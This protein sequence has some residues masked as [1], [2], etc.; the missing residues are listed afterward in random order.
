MPDIK[1]RIVGITVGIRFMR[2]FR[3]PDVSGE[4]IDSILNDSESPFDK[5][6]FPKVNETNGKVKTL[7]NEAGENLKISTDDFIL[8]IKIDN[9]FDKKIAFLKDKV[10]NYFNSV[11]DLFTIENIQRI[12]VMF[13]CDLPNSIKLND[14]VK[15]ITNNS[16]DEI[17]TFDLSFSQKKQTIDG[18][19][20]KGV[21]DYANVIYNLSKEKDR[22]ML[23][24]VFDFQRFFSPDVMKLKDAKLDVHLDSAIKALEEANNSWIKDYDEQPKK[25]T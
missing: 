5:K 14:T 18:F 1:K 11:F 16:V 7:F 8:S 22:D 4:I 20:K 25:T 2:T 17:Q 10:F 9:D 3:L 12:G 13:Y 19:L 24:Y 6:F 21:D 23:S 15:L